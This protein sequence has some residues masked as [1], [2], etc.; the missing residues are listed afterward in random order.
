MFLNWAVVTAVYE[1]VVVFHL[2]AAQNQ[3]KPVQA[4]ATSQISKKAKHNSATL[5]CQT[6]SHVWLSSHLLSLSEPDAREHEA[7]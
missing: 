3:F 4:A 2:N 7:F 1:T 6:V 5:S